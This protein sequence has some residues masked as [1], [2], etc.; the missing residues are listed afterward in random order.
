[1][2]GRIRGQNQLLGILLTLV[3][4]LLLSLMDLLAKYLGQSL[5]VAQIA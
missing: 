2:P 3:A 4:M 1:M 5:P